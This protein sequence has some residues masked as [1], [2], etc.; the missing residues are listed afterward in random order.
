MSQ[1]PH[2]LILASQSP[3]R[4]ELLT[5]AGYTFE[6]LVPDESAESGACAGE[7]PADLVA[8]LARQKAADVARRVDRGIVL[9]CDTVA[10]CQ[11]Q[12]LGKPLDRPDAQRMLRLLRGRIHHVYSGVCLWERPVDK[13]LNRVAATKLRMEEISDAELDAYLDSGAW[14]GK[15]GAFGYQ[16]RLGW[17]KIVEGSESNVV[18]LPMEM[19]AGMLAELARD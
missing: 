19:L 8:R 14:Q 15:A 6:V 7:T 4:R 10:E 9:A 13:R 1:P 16:D 5:E 17:I 2:R 12:V 11:G 3:R 18:G